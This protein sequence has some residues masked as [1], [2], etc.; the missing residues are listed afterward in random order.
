MSEPTSTATPEPECACD[1]VGMDCEIHG[2]PS[3]RGY[4][5]PEGRLFQRASDLAQLLEE[6]ERIIE[7]QHGGGHRS[8]ATCDFLAAAKEA[9]RR[10]P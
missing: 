8:C 6:A 10:K 5:D 7:R 9:L 1:L 4:S 2:T 3:E